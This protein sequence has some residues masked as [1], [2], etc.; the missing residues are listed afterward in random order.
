ML[1]IVCIDG[2]LIYKLPKDEEEEEE[3]ADLNL[4][5]HLLKLAPTLEPTSA[6]AT[7]RTID[8]KEGT[9]WQW[10]LAIK[11]SSNNYYNYY[12]AAM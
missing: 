12:S 2:G 3:E 1:P 10:P 6:T 5:V 4:Y 11:T 7:H 8:R 9:Q